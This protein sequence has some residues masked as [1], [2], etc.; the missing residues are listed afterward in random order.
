MVWQIKGA[1]LLPRPQEHGSRAG[2]FF[3]FGVNG[4]RS[5]FEVHLG[6]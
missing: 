2:F 3:G 6:V 4:T 1:A 5:Y